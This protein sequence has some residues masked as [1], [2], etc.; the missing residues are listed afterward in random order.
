MTDKTPNAFEKLPKYC[1]V[2]NDYFLDLKKA[3]M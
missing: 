2:N 3:N 1:K